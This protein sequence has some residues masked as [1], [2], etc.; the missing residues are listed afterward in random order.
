MAQFI[1][2]S[3]RNEFFIMIQFGVFVYKEANDAKYL[4]LVISYASER[5]IYAYGNFYTNTDNNE[6]FGLYVFDP[7]SLKLK[8]AFLLQNWNRFYGFNIAE[9]NSD[10]IYS[11]NNSTIYR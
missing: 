10:A 11:I 7:I 9:L 4:Q 1:K 5:F 2:M 3:N 6:L 8:M